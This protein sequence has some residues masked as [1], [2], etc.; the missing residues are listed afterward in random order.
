MP[1]Y[2]LSRFE[3]ARSRTMELRGSAQGI[4]TLGEK[5]LHAVL[6]RYY[7][8]DES[9]HERKVGR[10]TVDAIL[11]DG[12]ILEVQTRGFSSLRKKLPVLLS[13]GQVHL[14]APVVQKKW[15]CWLEPATGE[16]VSRRRSPKQYFPI[17][18]SRELSCIREFLSHPNLTVHFPLLEA[19]EYRLLD[20]WGNEGK[21]GSTR[22]ERIPLAL[23]DE[24]I[25]RRPEE[26]TLLLPE[27]LPKA[28]T[29]K[30]LQQAARVSSMCAYSAAAI[31]RHL[32]LIHTVGKQGR[33]ALWTV[34]T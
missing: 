31:L 22:Y 18:L 1:S 28:F 13:C 30:E 29:V 25:I 7:Q 34:S 32:G 23:L 9:L 8:P 2:P 21:R 11:S 17:D 6:K 3:T 15:V 20:G 27:G 16:V 19:E 5:S 24:W 14:I 12:S 33:A 10:M 4:G 26:Y